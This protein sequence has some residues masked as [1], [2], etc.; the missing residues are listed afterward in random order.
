MQEILSVNADKLKDDLTAVVK[1][2]NTIF[3]VHWDKARKIYKLYTKITQAEWKELAQ[4]NNGRWDSMAFRARELG[5]F[6]GR[7]KSILPE[8]VPTNTNIKHKLLLMGFLSKHKLTKVFGKAAISWVTETVLSN[9]DE[10]DKIDL[11]KLMIAGKMSRN[12]LDKQLYDIVK[13]DEET[14]KIID[15]LRVSNTGDPKDADRLLSFAAKFWM[16]SRKMNYVECEMRD[17]TKK[18]FSVIV[19]P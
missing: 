8:H 6:I 10:N 7:H 5:R 4:R 16:R 9:L 2:L 11:I 14:K 1:V 3:G 19:T 13:Q 12:E 17:K 15:T 18:L